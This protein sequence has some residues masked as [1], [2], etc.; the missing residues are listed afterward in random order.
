MHAPIPTLAV[1]VCLVA[2]VDPNLRMFLALISSGLTA[3]GLSKQVHLRLMRKSDLRYP[4]TS[5]CAC[6]R[7]VSIREYRLY[8]DI[9]DLIRTSRVNC[10]TS[11]DSKSVGR[12][13][14]RVTNY[15]DI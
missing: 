10:G 3:K 5:H 12:V 14:A 4:K 8:V 9:W 7:I 13:S 15:F 6:N 11:Y 1:S 2:V